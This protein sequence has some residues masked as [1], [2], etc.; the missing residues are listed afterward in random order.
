L[1]FIDGCSAIDD[2]GEYS[3]AVVVTVDDDVADDILT[4]IL[5]IGFFRFVGFVDGGGDG[6][7]CAFCFINDV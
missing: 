5:D 4:G 6:E 3:L 2:D 1:I 7:C